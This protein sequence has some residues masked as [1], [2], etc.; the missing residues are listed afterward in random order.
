MA[1]TTIDISTTT[2]APTIE[3][4]RNGYD[5][6]INVEPLNT[7]NVIEGYGSETNVVIEVLP[8][9]TRII[10]IDIE[11][12]VIHEATELKSGKLKLYP[13]L[14]ENIN[15][16]ITQKASTDNFNLKVDKIEDYELVS[17]SHL[18]QMARMDIRNFI[19]HM[20]TPLKEWKLTLTTLE[21]Q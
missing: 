14:G 15:G 18:I 11:R 7:I 9:E 17:I 5:I 12:G 2:S 21:N 20:E 10:A 1:N 16:T 19:F 8:K 6:E 4:S 3:V 13:S